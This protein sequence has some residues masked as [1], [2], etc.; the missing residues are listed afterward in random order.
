MTRKAIVF[1][2]GFGKR[3]LPFTEHTPKCLMRFGKYALIE[4]LLLQLQKAGVQQVMINIAHLGGLIQE[5]CQNGQRF[6][7]EITYSHEPEDKP[8][9][10]GGGVL[11]VLDWFEGEPFL[12]VS[13]DIYTDFD[14]TELACRTRP[15]AAHLV[16]VKQPAWCARADFYLVNSQVQFAKSSTASARKVPTTFSGLA[17][18]QPSLWD[19]YPRGGAFPLRDVLRQPIEH[20]WVTGQLFEGV[21]HNIGCKDRVNELMASAHVRSLPE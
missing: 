9:E 20:K 11:K 15:Q 8:L 14:F 6:G 21:W 7:L 2:A 19:G 17:L 16:L 12:A 18:L 5:F 4:R 10:T 13:S 3:L 1:A